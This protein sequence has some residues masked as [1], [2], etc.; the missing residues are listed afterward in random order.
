MSREVQRLEKM[1]EESGIKLPSIATDITGVSGRA[2]L[3]APIEGQ[4]DP[5]VLADLAKKA[6]RRKIP[7][8]PE[9]R[10]GRFNAH[11]A[12]TT[13]LFLSRIDAHSKDMAL[14]DARIEELMRPFSGAR[15]LLATIP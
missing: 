13:G 3:Q 11:H 14:L 1:L 2:M 8:M 10:T 6:M 4:H 12:F 9:A 15:E 7:A 5:A